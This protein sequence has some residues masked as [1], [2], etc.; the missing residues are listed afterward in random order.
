VAFVISGRSAF[1]GFSLVAHGFMMFGIEQIEA[2]KSREVTAIQIAESKKPAKK[3]EAKVEPPPSKPQPPAREKRAS[4]PKPAEAPPP[5]AAPPLAAAPL[6]DMPD[7]GVSLS[8]GVDGTGFAMPSGDGTRPSPR[9]APPPTKAAPK[10]LSAAAA[11]AV[12]DGCEEPAAKPKPR[13][14][15]QP[16]YTDAARAAMV[17][18]KVRV[19]LTVDEAGHVVS[20]KLLQGLGYGLDEAAL[21]AARQAEFEPAV[22]CGK[23][24]SATF[25]ISM[26]FSLT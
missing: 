7:F 17:E 25:N 23:P 18:G 19:Q 20:V 4:A 14:V 9:T 6:A 3:P 13:S 16:G 8:G 21:A 5:E 12:V 24:T 15:P 11:P 22:R 2:K 26:R 1:I 10:Q